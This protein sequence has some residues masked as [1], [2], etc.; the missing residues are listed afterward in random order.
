MS[1]NYDRPA[2]HH[3]LVACLSIV[4]ILILLLPIVGLVVWWFWP[5]GGSGIN[6][7]V[8]PRLVSA[9]GELAELE[10]MN[11][12]I[13]ERVSPCL[14]QVTNLAQRGSWFGLDVQQV[15]EGVGSGFVWDQDGHI[16]TNFHVVKGGNAAQVTLADHSSYEAEDVWAYPDR[17]IAV[18]WI[19]APRSKLHPIEV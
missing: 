8:Q 10:K 18:I 19:K 7:L 6:P 3:P 1:M 17:D 12:D 13:Y 14:V 2:T 9:R 4:L 5:S 16:V 11:I 15:P